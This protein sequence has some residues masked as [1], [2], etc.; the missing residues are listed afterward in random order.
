MDMLCSRI[1]GAVLGA[2]MGAALGVPVRHF[3]LGQIREI[4]GQEGIYRYDIGRQTCV[5]RVPDEFRMMLYTINGL[6]L[7]DPALTPV[8]RIQEAW[9]ESGEAGQG[10]EHH[11]CRCW[12]SD[13][14]CAVTGGLPKPSVLPVLP[15]GLWITDS[16]YNAIR[17]A[18]EAEA[19]LGGSPGDQ[20]AAAALVGCVYHLIRDTD[21]ETAIPETALSLLSLYGNRLKDEMKD[22]IEVM[23]LAMALSLNH[24]S[25][26]AENILLLT[27]Q[28]EAYVPLAIGLYCALRYPD[29][30]TEAIVA[31]VNHSG[32]SAISGAVAGCLTG[33]RCGIYSI[34]PEDW[35]L[36]CGLELLPVTY[37][38]AIELL[39]G[40]SENDRS[41]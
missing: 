18:M 19:A 20:L 14:H 21:L 22:L 10:S 12:I 41:R 30:Y 8:Q 2:A 24:F 13:Y 39:Y 26:D 15:L 40:R 17:L 6:R 35:H 27:G 5:A 28:T 23:D 16:S 3:T 36:F 29:N 7:P 11:G 31:A 1:L 4:Y 33:A 9:R 32:D 25:T 37:R 34:E 38:L